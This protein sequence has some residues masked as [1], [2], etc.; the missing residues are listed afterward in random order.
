MKKRLLTVSCLIG[1]WP[2]LT[3][4]KEYKAYVVSNAHF[5]SQWNWDVQTSINEYVKN[6]LVR[7]LWLLDH[8]P[9]YVFNFEGGVKYDWMKE[10]YPEEYARMKEYIRQGRW[11]VTGSTW[12]ATDPNIPSPESFFKNILLGQD[13]YEKE[14]GVTAKDIFL[15]DC[16]GFGYTLPT[17]AAHAGLIGFSTQKL[18]WRQRPFYGESKVPFNIGLWQGVDG[19]RIM[20]ALNAKDYTHKWHGED[21]SDNEELINLAKESINNTAYRYYGTGD[22]GGSPTHKSIVSL[23]KGIEGKGK[24]EI[25]SAG[26]DQ[27]FEDYYP[28]DKH[29]E[30][31][32]FDG[33]LLMDVHA[34]GCYTSQSAMKQFNRRN[35]QLGDAAERISVL[36]NQVC[37]SPY[38]TAVLNE[39]WKRFIWHQFHD[40]LTGT[41]IPKAYTYSWN[42][43]LIAQ[44]RFNDIIR[45]GVGNIARTMDTRVAGIPVIVYNPLSHTRK[46]VA[47]ANIP[48][49]NAPKGV[50]VYDANGKEVA[51]QLTGYKNGIASLSFSTETAPV[52]C[53]VYDIRFGNNTNKMAGVKVSD[54]SLEN[55]IYKL[56]LNEQGDIASL[57]DKRT[58]K[59][60]VQSGKAFRLALFTDNQSHDWPAWEILK[61]TMDQPARSV[62]QDVRIS[63]EC[64]GPHIGVLKVERSFGP[65]HFVQYIRMTEGST[66]D[67]IDIKNEVD[68]KSSNALLKAEF[69]FAFENEKATYD[70]G[71]GTIQ[72]GNNTPTA[73]EVYAQ[74]WADITSPDG[75]AG[76]AILN[77]CK[78]GWDKPN[79]NTLRLT[80]LHT[81]GTKNNY[82][83]Q[84][85]QD[86]GLHSFTYS[87][88]SHQQDPLLSDI[89]A[90][91]DALNN[92]LFTY[93][94]PKQRGKQG[95]QIALIESV[96]P[97]LVVKSVKKAENSDLTVIR[98]YETLGKPVTDG[99]LTFNREIEAVQELNGVE[100]P[101]GN[102]P[103]EGNTVFLST[104]AYKPKT[105]S[106]RF[107]KQESVQPAI[108][109]L[110]I[111]LPYTHQAF[112]AEPFHY[113]G[114]FDKDGNSYSA[115]LIDKQITNG[116]VTYE[117]GELTEN[118]VVKCKGQVIPLPQDAN[119]DKVYLLVAATDQDQ[120]VEF[121]IDQN[122]TSALIPYYSGFFGQW[123]NDDFS[124]SFIKD[125][126]LAYVGSHRHSRKGNDAYTFTYMYEVMLPLPKG[127]KEL[128]L[129]DN[130]NIA[131]FAASL[132]D[133]YADNIENA[134]EM[135]ALPLTD[136]LP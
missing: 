83:Y 5:D 130:E 31:P 123:G 49:K 72:R 30:L 95:R 74:Q 93:L 127:A 121:K 90:K 88:V 4:Q 37:G 110:P 23:E 94:A 24:V 27:I 62:D 10:Y 97:Q 89:P 105:I 120:Q 64:S 86:I 82:A 43:E 47:E 59:E 96:T 21:I 118:N 131:V 114:S 101:I 126:R 85:R 8:Y 58:E 78:Y 87:I 44:S 125:A 7:N 106:V 38:P 46:E 103:F 14:F 99:K 19:S 115:E 98:L 111:S 33:E 53:S 66:D 77:D 116:N 61:K 129:P 79:N 122:T 39:S 119:M 54:R 34:T 102:L 70:L 113:T 40:D 75:T 124:K 11:H 108:R 60:L 107:K 133:N 128:I 117:M 76:V 81:P 25:I 109:N 45:Q 42:D 28:F 135:R 29:P 134:R 56:T 52:S 55:S 91:A 22:I 132:S 17:I 51:A 32:V 63:V 112:T 36:A 13:F 20:A 65:S 16:F 48:C 3:A 69:P 35:E 9:N 2:V 15:P 100:K 67:R 68:W 41:S 104:T 12:D 136:L 50:R 26:S 71:I 18:Q 57:I 73:Y 92:P 84:N 80:L 6:T 1:L